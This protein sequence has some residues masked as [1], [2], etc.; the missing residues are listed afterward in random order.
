MWQPAPDSDPK[1]HASLG[2]AGSSCPSTPA[3]ANHGTPRIS[4]VDSTWI[5]L[6]LEIN[7]LRLADGDSDLYHGVPHRKATSGVAGI[8]YVGYPVSL[9]IHASNAGTRLRAATSR[10]YI[11]LWVLDDAEAVA[12]RHEARFLELWADPEPALRPRVE[13]VRGRFGNPTVDRGADPLSA[14]PASGS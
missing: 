2:T 12:Q 10:G 6:I 11:E 7:D 3:H 1:T 9:G 5:P 4:G 13:A 8:G 14:P